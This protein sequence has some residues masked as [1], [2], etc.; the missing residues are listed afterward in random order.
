MSDTLLRPDDWDEPVVVPDVDELTTVVVPFDG[1]HSS[2]RALAWGELVARGAG[3]E[4]VVVVAF[5]APL[6]KK[7]RGAIYV[8]DMRAALEAEAKALAA[9][10]VE[11]LAA[12]GTKARGIVVQG[13]ASAATLDVAETE[14]AQLIVLGRRGLAHELPGVAGSLERFRS[15]MSGGV[16]ERVARHADVAVMVV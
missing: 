15:T 14:N 3:A 8:D 5:E 2:E 11:T 12:R 9:E 6:T 13:E 10:A 1:S 7:G 16:A 4:V